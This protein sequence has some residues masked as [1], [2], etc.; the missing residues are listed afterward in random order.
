MDEARTCH[1]WW[2]Y[3]G[4]ALAAERPT[5][6]HVDEQGRL[7]CPD[8]PAIAY[9]DGWSVFAWHGLRIED[10]DL[11]LKPE[12]VTVARIRDEANAEIRRMLLTRYGFDRF[13]QDA[14]ALPVHADAFGTVYRCD[15]A[16]DEPLVIVRVTNSTPEPDGSIKE[17]ALRVHPE[18]RPMHR[19]GTYG[20]PQPLTARNAVASSF[21]L[22]GEQYQP[23][24]ET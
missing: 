11:I 24:I 17:Y 7:H 23:A 4:L 10:A 20:D 14:G 6:L 16:D 22:R 8:G 18:L 9:A 12:G 15:L 5:T 1:W 19:D 13:V 3:K 21:G 2:P